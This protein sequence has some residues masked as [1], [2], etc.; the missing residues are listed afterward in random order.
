M[1]NQSIP[2]DLA[3]AIQARGG[4]I[5]RTDPEIG[6]VTVTGLSSAAVAA[7]TARTD[8]EGIGQDVVKRWL[9]HNEM[10]RV[11]RLPSVHPTTD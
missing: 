1:K 8:V 6:M 5:Q 11:E 7:L 2:A 9:P 4:S 10:V 3:A